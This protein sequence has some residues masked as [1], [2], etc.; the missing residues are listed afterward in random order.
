M[1]AYNLLACGTFASGAY[2]LPDT[3]ETKCYQGSSPYAEISCAGTG[4]DGEYDINPMSYTDNGNGTVTD[5]NTGLIWQKQDDGNT[6]NWY[7]AS[8]TY[9]ADYNPDSTNICGSLSLDGYSEWR[10]PTVK[11]LIGLIDYSKLW[12]VPMINETFFPSTQLSK[13]WT[14]TTSAQNPDAAWW[15]PFDQ[16]SPVRYINPKY[17]PMY[18]RCVHGPQ[19]SGNLHANGNGTVTD[20]STGLL[21][22]QYGPG[23]MTWG[24][25][26]ST[27]QG[28]ELGGHTDW[29]LPNVKELESLTDDT[30]YFPTLNTTFFPDT[31]TYPGYWTS[32]SQ[33][34][35][36]NT[37]DAAY[38]VPFN[39]G[40]RSA[41]YKTEAYNVRCVSGRSGFRQVNILKDYY[42]GVGSGTVTSQPSGI[43]CDAANTACSAY[44]LLNGVVSLDPTPDTDGSIFLGWAGDSDCYDGQIA[45]D[46]DKNC[47]AIF[48]LCSPSL[49]VRIL[50]G[51]SYYGSIG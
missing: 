34:Y 35:W 50:Y 11:E 2:R 9:N 45:M 49:S 32:T 14:S 22:Q 48:T 26:V 30:R 37:T 12:P 36:A 19:L 39:D 24:N 6:Y 27:C 25:A 51:S 38:F 20:A 16:T 47:T 44:F 28:L 42:A 3:G 8:G 40:S 46:S 15:V 10:L 43:N 1:L 41:Y 33:M 18:V 23:V 4:Q 31:S 17:D 13:Y 29:R 21:W 7:Q 5:N